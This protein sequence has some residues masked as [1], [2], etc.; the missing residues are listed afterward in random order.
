MTEDYVQFHTLVARGDFDYWPQ[1]S[2]PCRKGAHSA[3]MRNDAGAISYYVE[4]A[5][6]EELH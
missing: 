1:P 4:C 5:S 2:R 6:Y 3:T